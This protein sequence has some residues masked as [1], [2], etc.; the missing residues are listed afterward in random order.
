MSV[1]KTN[2][3]FKELE[4]E[5][6]PQI[7]KILHHPFLNRIKDAWLNRRQLHY[8][9]GQYG[10]YCRYFPRFLAAA[11]ANIPDDATR[12]SLIENLWEEHGEGK[13]AK[14][15]RILYNK[16]AN[17]LDYDDASL[18]AVTALPTTDICIQNML[19]LCRDQHFLVG[20]GALGPGTEYFTNDEYKIIESGLKK[21]DFLTADD[22]EFWT[23]HISL[24]EHHYSDMIDAI[25]AWET[26]DDSRE[27]IRSGAHKALAL[28]YIFWEGLEDNL[29][30][31]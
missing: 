6:A 7:D 1:G 28:E 9:A 3:F 14:S 13:L 10:I 27:K 23:V 22:Y 30:G 20:L 12:M 16:F 4:A 25:R 21:Y 18:E 24:D 31:K 17:A 29:P 2:D 19:D 15:H 5:L 26:D 11:A 8:F